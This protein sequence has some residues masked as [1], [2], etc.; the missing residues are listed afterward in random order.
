MS[1]PIESYDLDALTAETVGL[2]HEEGE[3]ET[4]PKLKSTKLDRSGYWSLLLQHVSR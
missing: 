4:A 1:T 3:E 2:L